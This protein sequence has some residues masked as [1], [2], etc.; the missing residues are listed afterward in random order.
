MGGRPSTLLLRKGRSWR[1]PRPTRLPHGALVPRLVPFLYLPTH[2]YVFASGLQWQPGHPWVV[3]ATV[4]LK[5]DFPLPRVVTRVS[6]ASQ[7]SVVRWRV[8]GSGASLGRDQ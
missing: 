1:M 5:Q 8:E 4:S 6:C 7:R 2:F 3:I